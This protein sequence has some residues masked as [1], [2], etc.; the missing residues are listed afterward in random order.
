[1]GL[2]PE[3]VANVYEDIEQKRRAAEYLHAKP[4]L[5]EPVPQLAPF[6]ID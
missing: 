1:M 4:L 2:T 6:A 3:R 5:L